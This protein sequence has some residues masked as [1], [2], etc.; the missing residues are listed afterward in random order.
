MRC[1]LL[2]DTLDLRAHL[3]AEIARLSHEID[4]VDHPDTSPDAVEMAVAWYP[5]AD[6]FARYPNL[7]AV[8]SIAA[9]ADSILHCPSL[10]DGIPVVRVVEPAQAQMMSGFVLWHVI[11]H[12]RGFATHVAQ[13]RARRWERFPQ[14]AASDVP[15]GILGFGEMGGRVAGDLA[16]L[17]FAVHVWSRNARPTPDGVIGFHGADGLAAMLVRTEVLIN[18]LP[19]THET[20]GILNATLFARMKRGGYLIQVGRGEHLVEDDLLAALDCG[21]LAGASLDVFL[22]EPLQPQHPFWAHPNIVVTPHD[23]CDVSIPAV[24]QSIEA[25]AAALRSGMMPRNA[26]DRSRGY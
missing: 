24:G 14:R 12:Q 25:T 16:R 9:G 18:L 5:P 1:V 22:T 8:C 23:A 13:Q 3:A 26:V 2:S 20:R 4:F 10:R 17:G 15:V 7:K 6:G 19:L 21:Q 11:W